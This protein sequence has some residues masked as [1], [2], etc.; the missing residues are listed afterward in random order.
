M[1]DSPLDLI[2]FKFFKLFAQYESSLKERGFYRVSGKGGI[3]VD[4]DRF[5]C[6]R[7]GSDFLAQMGDQAEAATFILNAPPQKQ[8]V[9]ANGHIVWQEVANDDQSVQALFGHL[10]RMR[11]NLFHGAKFNGTWFD[12][13]RSHDLL[14]RG[15]QI[16]EFYRAR[17]P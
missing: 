8:A 14:V 17:L 9:D 13:Q 4:W 16:L 7:I 10:S 3:I 2:A 12:P 1:T 5:A 6:D 15:V 11:N